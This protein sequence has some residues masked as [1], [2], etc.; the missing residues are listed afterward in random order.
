MKTA[1]LMLL[2]LVVITLGVTGCA[3]PYGMGTSYREAAFERGVAEM[4]ELVDRTVKDPERAKQAQA[5]LQDIVAEVLQSY[6]QTRAY[7]EKLYALNADYEAPPEQFGKVL[8]ELNNV[9]T[10]SA[11]KILGL[12]FMMKGIL[13]AQ[14]WK[15]LADAMV[16]ARR[17]YAPKAEGM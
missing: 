7:H 1:K 17:H 13:T 4:N 5:I 8:E 11:S 3:R 6:K 14:E 9:R 15:E 10:A 16:Q 2:A 12:R